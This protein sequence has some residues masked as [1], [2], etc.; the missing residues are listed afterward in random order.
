MGF[1]ESI[2]SCLIPS[3]ICGAFKVKELSEKMPYCYLLRRQDSDLEFLWLVSGHFAPRVMTT[4]TVSTEIKIVVQ[5]LCISTVLFLKG[6]AVN[7]EWL[8]QNGLH[9]IHSYDEIKYKEVCGGKG[10]F[11]RADGAVAIFYNGLQSTASVSL[12]R[13]LPL[14]DLRIIVRTEG[15]DLP[16]CEAIVG[17]EPSCT[18][19]SMRRFIAW[20][21]IFLVVL[22]AIVLIPWLMGQALPWQGLGAASLGFFILGAN[23]GLKLLARSSTNGSGKRGTIGPKGSAGNL[24]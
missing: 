12:N 23:L 18:S 22:V 16:K 11:L 8:L 9:K 21:I 7:E 19:V 1:G 24:A 5:S 4:A 3:M 14:R 20:H 10:W 13:A 17:G 2:R 6:D 15:D